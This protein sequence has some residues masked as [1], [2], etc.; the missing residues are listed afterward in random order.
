[1]PT[2]KAPPGTEVSSTSVNGEAIHIAFKDG[3]YS[4]KKEEEVLVLDAVAD[5]EG[6][7]IGHGDRD[8]KES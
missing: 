1:M 7:P 6:H 4:T 5:T 3:T 8:V 2:Y